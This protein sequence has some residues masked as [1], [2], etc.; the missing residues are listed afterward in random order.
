MVKIDLR[1]CNEYGI[2]IILRDIGDFQYSKMRKMMAIPGIFIIIHQYPNNA[3][4]NDINWRH[5]V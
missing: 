3:T 2:W 4:L 5:L 1:I